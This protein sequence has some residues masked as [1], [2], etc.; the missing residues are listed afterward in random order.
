MSASLPRK[1]FPNAPQKIAQRQYKK[2]VAAKELLRSRKKLAT[3][4]D[5]ELVYVREIGTVLGDKK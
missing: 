5:N 3:N 4:K 1:Y 2:L